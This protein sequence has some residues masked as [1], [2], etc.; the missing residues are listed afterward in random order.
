MPDFVEKV[1][2]QRLKAITASIGLGNVNEFS[3]LQMKFP[4]YDSNFL[5]LIAYSREDIPAQQ[6]YVEANYKQFHKVL[7]SDFP[8]LLSQ[9]TR[10]ASRMWEMILCDVLSS[11]GELVPKKSSGADFLLRTPG[12]QDIQIEAIAPDEACDEGL[13]ARRPDYSTSNMAEVSGHIEDLE[14]PILL[15][16]HHGIREKAGSYSRNHPL[17]VAINSS[18]AVGFVSLDEY[19]LR[20]VLFGLGATTITRSGVVGLEQR[21]HLNKPGGTDFPVA[22]FRD[23]EYAHISGVI[24]TSQNPL[25]LIPGGYGWTN[26]GIT[27]VPNPL[28]SRK[29]DVIFP[30]MKRLECDDSLYREI[31]APEKFKSVVIS[32]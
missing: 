28:A 18:K 6:A 30:S 8:R 16:V 12:G 25:G 15:R 10:F 3:A 27:Y 2:D 4:E 7:D 1:H 23:P 14:R 20:R 17:I 13:R 24:Y 21:P 22:V 31:A 26:Q 32:L 29:A 5:W 9:K 11:S 19:V